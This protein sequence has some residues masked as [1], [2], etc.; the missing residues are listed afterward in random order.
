MWHPPDASLC[1]PADGEVPLKSAI[2]RA[3]CSPPRHALITDQ[4]ALLTRGELKHEG[5]VQF[6]DGA[7]LAKWIWASQEQLH[8]S[9]HLY[10]QSSRSVMA[11]ERP[12]F[13]YPV[14]AWNIV[15]AMELACHASSVRRA[16]SMD[17]KTLDPESTKTTP[18]SLSEMSSLIACYGNW[19]KEVAGK[20]IVG[21]LPKEVV[22]SAQS[23]AP[24]DGMTG[25]GGSY[26]EAMV[27]QHAAL[28]SIAM[29]F[30]HVGDRYVRLSLLL[31][32]LES[33]D[34]QEQAEEEKAHASKLAE[35]FQTMASSI[36]IMA[37]SID[38]SPA[39]PA[40]AAMGAAAFEAA[41]QGLT[42]SLLAISAGLKS[43][44]EGLEQQ[45]LHVVG[46][47]L[48]E[49]SQA[50]DSS[51][52]L[53]T[54][55]NDLINA[56]ASLEQTRLKADQAA[57]RITF[58]DF[59]NGQPVHVNTV[60]R[61]TYNTNLLRYEEALARA[62][63]LAFIA[64]RA[65]ELRF[66]VDM[67]TMGE[68]M[69]LVDPPKEW[70]ADVCTMKGIDYAAIRNGT[71]DQTQFEFGSEVPPG[72]HFA[73]EFI[74]DY[75]SQLE[76]FVASYPFDFPLKDGD[77]TA[78]L[79]LAEDIY[80]LTASCVRPSVNLLYFSTEFDRRDTDFVEDQT[81]GWFVHGCEQPPAPEDGGTEPFEWAG[82]V[83]ATPVPAPEPV[84]SDGGVLNSP[85]PEG[86]L[87]YLVGNRPC[88]SGSPGVPGDPEISCPD[89]FG[90][91]A[92]GVLAQR[93]PTLDA[94][95]YQLSLYISE[96]ASAAPYSG[97]NQAAA[98][99]VRERDDVEVTRAEG[100]PGPWERVSLGF[101]ADQGERYR[102]EILP[103]TVDVVLDTGSD[104]GPDAWPGLLVSAAQVEHVAVLSSG[105]AEPSSWEYT[106]VNQVAAQPVCHERVGPELRNQF[107][108]RCMQVCPEGIKESC[109]GSTSTT[110]APR[111]C[112]Y[113]STFSIGLED[114]ESGRLI[115]SGQLAIGNFNLRHNRAGVNLVGTNVTS[116]D[117]VQGA[118][119]YG[120]GF[121]QYT[122]IHSGNTQ[123]RNYEGG[124][125][126]VHMDPGFIEHGKS[127][128]AER[129][130]TN[131]PS[132][133]D[134]GA[135]EAYMKD[136]FKGRP[137]QGMYT[138]RIWDTPTLQ[139]HQVEDVQ[140]VWNY[141][142]WTRF[143]H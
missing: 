47:A 114:V 49:V 121:G 107:R 119:C 89:G 108:R 10:D 20:T 100:V 116:C 120:N 24:L 58:Q 83:V 143:K 61:R 118:S 34:R 4:E 132:S 19:M 125:L 90:E 124:T 28:S 95:A 52:A 112:F 96:A 12:P 63:R 138:L 101:F 104:A 40:K 84:V 133:A 68:D 5:N 103:S 99:I 75:V 78:V 88:Q 66:G 140:L 127:L 72:D 80:R 65:I 15:D 115:P 64:K 98:R 43:T 109:K 53:S 92:A 137:L 77:D 86:A 41:Q 79:S 27:A 130:V 135:L 9:Q 141:H 11:A 74:G 44:K 117:S 110:S 97:G 14:T 128:A 17:C 18:L 42:Q 51:R 23:N 2:W 22:Q 87:A 106:D 131:P 94:G 70:A 67:A 26:L 129:T 33:L 62:R 38:G 30:D 60:M 55:I 85:L 139:W 69:V 134:M 113:E 123:I 111:V 122:L 45:R 16:S 71:G 126:D 31:K 25:I 76:D 46:S 8:F 32:E 142:Y 3:F 91:R 56:S 1:N 57:A 105:A 82:C 7:T 73:D 35:S 48:G 39:A 13:Q 29:D 21:P 37:Q 6:L 81:R 136:E 93:L 102:V 54:H 50:K 36:Q 59:V